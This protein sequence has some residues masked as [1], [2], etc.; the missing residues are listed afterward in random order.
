[1]IFDYENWFLP[2]LNQYALH[3]G[4]LPDPRV[5]LLIGSEK[6]L[7]DIDEN[8]PIYATVAS[9][10]AL[11][12]LKKVSSAMVGETLYLRC[13]LLGHEEHPAGG[14]EIP[15]MWSPN[16]YCLCSCCQLSGE[17]S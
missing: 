16:L 15:V 7:S 14:G 9:C 8:V 12:D 6:K 1:M 4:P 10:R 5:F 3:G 17:R 13:L 11:Q 2:A